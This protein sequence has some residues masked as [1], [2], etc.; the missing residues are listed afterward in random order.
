LA[1]ACQFFVELQSRYIQAQVEAGAQA[2]WLGDCNAFSGFLSV[3]QYR[4]YAAPACKK[5][6]ENAH[7]AGAII[8]LMNSEVSIPH[9]LAEAELGV[10]IISCGPAADMAEVRKAL[11]G[12][13]C[14]SG[15]LD[16]IAV[17]MRGTPDVVAAD[18]ER[19]VRL[20]HPGGGYLFSTGEMNPRDTP[21]ENMRAMIAAVRRCGIDA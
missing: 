8:H 11:T 3:D 16:P 6:V 2:I 5:L 17:L 12:K 7:E 20:C 19:I 10:D 9:L 1:E 15:N 13:V 4:K 14:F 21:E 18:A